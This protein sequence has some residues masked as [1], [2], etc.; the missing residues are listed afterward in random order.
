[1]GTSLPAI[2]GTILVKMLRT[3]HIFTVFKTLK[4]SAKCKDFALIIY[5]VLIVQPIILLQTL[6]TAIDPYHL[7][8][9]FIEHPGFT[10]I[11]VGCYG[12]YT[13]I[14]MS[15]ECTYNILLSA[16][17]IIIAIKSRKIQRTEFKDTKKVILFI[18]IFFILGIW[19]FPHVVLLDY[20]GYRSA[21]P[22]FSYLACI[23][24]ALSCQFLLF[25]PK[26]WPSIQNKIF[27]ALD[28][29]RKLKSD[30]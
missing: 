27:K 12:H 7:I 19:C 15:L 29:S 28:A 9:N 21:F 1:M 5:V 24:A 11:D 6:W 2:L 26:L 14:W 4:Q 16:A 25:V 18:F 3:Y 10:W 30:I 20:I 17:V 13:H 8:V 23:T 22:Y